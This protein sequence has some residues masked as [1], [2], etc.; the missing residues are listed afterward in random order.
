MTSKIYLIIALIAYLAIIGGL[1]FWLVSAKPDEIK[2]KVPQVKVVSDQVFKDPV[3][4]QMKN[5]SQ[6]GQIPVTVDKNQQGK[7]NPFVP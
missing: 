7:D 3:L 5:F 6:F 2:T 4:N 1:S